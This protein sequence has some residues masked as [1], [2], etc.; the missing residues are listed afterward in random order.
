MFVDAMKGRF[1]RDGALALFDWLEDLEEGTEQRELDG[2]A[3]KCEFCEYPSAIEAAR[4]QGGF[5]EIVG[6]DTKDGEEAALEWLQDRTSVIEFD[7][8]VII[9]NF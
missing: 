5:F 6:E 1:S 2:V 4:T 3:I 8:G 9:Q 7:G